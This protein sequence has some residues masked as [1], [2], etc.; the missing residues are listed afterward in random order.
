MITIDEEVPK[1]K[2][3]SSRKTP[4]KADHKHK[5]VNCVFGYNGI[6]FD[7]ECGMKEIPVKSIGTYCEICGKVGS[8]I[9]RKW[10]KD[11]SQWYGDKNYKER[12]NN[13]ALVEFDESSRTLPYFWLDDRWSANKFVEMDH[14]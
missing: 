14:V 10:L 11:T 7:K 13:K 1:Y 3:R 9:D 6:L 8:V 2:K 4:K 12:W 5:Y